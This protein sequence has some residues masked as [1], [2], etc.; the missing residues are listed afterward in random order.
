MMTE[1]KQNAM[2][3]GIFVKILKFQEAVKVL[4]IILEV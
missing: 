4:G 1:V 2:K 3:K